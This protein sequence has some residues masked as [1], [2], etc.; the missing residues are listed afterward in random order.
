MTSDS[1]GP[2]EAD[3]ATDAAAAAAAAEAA[4]RRH[5]EAVRGVE[6]QSAEE[7]ALLRM[8]LQEAQENGE[9]VRW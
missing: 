8:E 5:G 1:L 7:E 3:A 9:M 6:A 4:L 2:T